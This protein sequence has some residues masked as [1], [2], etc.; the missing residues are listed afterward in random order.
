MPTFRQNGEA[1]I[2]NAADFKQRYPHIWEEL[3]EQATQTL[4]RAN[5]DGE[6]SNGK[7][8]TPTVTVEQPKDDRLEKMAEALGESNR[9]LSE[10]M[11]QRKQEGDINI[12]INTASAR[13]KKQG[14]LTRAFRNLHADRRQR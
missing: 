1:P 3:W 10:M 11:Q 7:T 4:Q 12:T 2:A 9:L 5:V 14:M 8:G 13:T 6:G